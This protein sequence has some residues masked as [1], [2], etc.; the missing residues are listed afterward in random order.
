[1]PN[2]RF[3]FALLA[4]ALL[5]CMAIAAGQ[6]GIVLATGATIPVPGIKE[7]QELAG[8]GIAT[9]FITLAIFAIASWTWVFKWMV[10]QVESQRKA[11][12]ELNKDLI[13]YMKADRDN[14]LVIVTQTAELLRVVVD[15]IELDERK[16]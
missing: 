11:N 10:N 6:V 9:W 4:T 12:A 3:T 7:A 14:L 2:L 16:K 1:M 5:P 8:A 15:K 13:S